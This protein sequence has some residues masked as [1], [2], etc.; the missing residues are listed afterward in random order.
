MGFLIQQKRQRW[1][2]TRTVMVIPKLL[3]HWMRETGKALL[4]KI[5]HYTARQDLRISSLNYARNLSHTREMWDFYGCECFVMVLLG[6]S[7]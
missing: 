1:T 2:T 4:F 3:C 5:T 7:V 6:L